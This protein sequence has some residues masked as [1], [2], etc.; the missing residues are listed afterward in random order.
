MYFSYTGL[1]FF[2]FLRVCITLYRRKRYDK[3]RNKD[4]LLRG[5]IY[6]GILSKQFNCILS[7]MYYSKIRKV[8]YN[9]KKKVLRNMFTKHLF[10]FLYKTYLF[11]RN[12]SALN[13]HL[14]I[15]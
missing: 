12:N 9:Y 2:Y 8:S 10:I 1:F 13:L 14:T 6:L 4:N 5:H 3:I 15:N 7:K 11:I